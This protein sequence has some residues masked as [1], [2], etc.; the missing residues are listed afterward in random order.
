MEVRELRRNKV[1]VEERG[2]G[3][4]GKQGA[5]G[6]G[7]REQ[8]GN[9]VTIRRNPIKI[10]SWLIILMLVVVGVVEYNLR[11]AS[12]KAARVRLVQNGVYKEKEAV[13]NL[14]RG[15]AIREKIKWLPDYLSERLFGNCRSLFRAQL[16]GARLRYAHLRHAHLRDARLR[17]AVLFSADLSDADL[18][19]ADLSDANL[20]D[21]NLSDAD[22]FYADLR[23]ADLYQSDLRFADLR[24]AVLSFANLSDADLSN[25]DLFHAD[26]SNADLFHAD[27]S[28]A[29]LSNAVLFHADLRDAD[30]RDADLSNAILFSTDFRA[31]QEITQR[32]LE[33]D[34]PPLICNSPLPEG[35]E[36][37]GDRDCEQLAIALIERYPGRFASMSQAEEFVNQKR[38]KKWG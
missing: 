25:A 35:I 14:V 1:P 24:F 18:S 4:Q 2:W 15:C 19:D 27:L 29:D 28:N 8:G 30:L 10:A 32:Q 22:L 31:T 13:E 9:I 37:N 21:A 34:N 17:D 3:E 36:I 16:T 20:S 6:W 26:L 33:G 38:H 7:D 5:P 12:V 11:E 23:E